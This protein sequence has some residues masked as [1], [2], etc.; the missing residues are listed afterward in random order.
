M[1]ILEKL[2]W[3]KKD[4]FET[5][6]S[7]LENICA[8][9]LTVQAQL[10]FHR[11]QH[12][13]IQVPCLYWL[14]QFWHKQHHQHL[15][16]VCFSLWLLQRLNMI[17]MQVHLSQ[18]QSKFRKKNKKSQFSLHFLDCCEVFYNYILFFFLVFSQFF[19]SLWK[20][21]FSFLN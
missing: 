19:F 13:L 11:H 21:V 9:L 2:W 12:I 1:E 20:K 3:K 18:C 5:I 7:F 10:F 16:L 14:W 8:C 15:Y 6:L 17:K 4:N